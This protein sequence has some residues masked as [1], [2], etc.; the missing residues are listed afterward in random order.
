[1]AASA[2]RALS[3]QERAD[4]ATD[5]VT[6]AYRRE[7]GLVALER[8]VIRANRTSHPF[9][10]AFVDLDDLK[11]TNDSLGHAAGDQLLK[12]V[13]DSIRAHLR[14]YDLLV[15][16]GG[17][18]FLCGLSDLRMEEA[19]KRFK[20]VDEDLERTHQ[21]AVTVGLTELQADDSLEGLIARADEEMYRER[22]KRRV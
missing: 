19:T 8:E 6:G 5:S 21:A 2:D 18:E 4:F 11:G 10:L 22:H 17:D 13:A 20:L 14:P 3:A 9:T 15:R 7:V 16:F 1:V 12:S